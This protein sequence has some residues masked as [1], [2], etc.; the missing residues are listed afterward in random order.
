MA[1]PEE[2]CHADCVDEVLAIEL[3]RHVV[4]IVVDTRKPVL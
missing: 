3:W 1:Q 4:S 2:I